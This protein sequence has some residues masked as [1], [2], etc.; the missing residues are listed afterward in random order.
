MEAPKC[1]R[2]KFQD[3]SVRVRTFVLRHRG[4]AVYVSG[5]L[6]TLHRCI[7]V[8]ALHFERESRPMFR[9]VILGRTLPGI[10]PFKLGLTYAIGIVIS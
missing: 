8:N 7:W 6:R 2:R 9:P 1:G 3:S 5:P 4:L 10:S